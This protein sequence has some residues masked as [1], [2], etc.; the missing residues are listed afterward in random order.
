[1]EIDRVSQVGGLRQEAEP[2]WTREKLR[3]RKFVQDVPQP[4]SEVEEME[5]QAPERVDE[6]KR[7]GT[8]DV[9]A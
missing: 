2:L 8:L 4:E 5:L 7:D 3:R 6:E 9:I 1:M